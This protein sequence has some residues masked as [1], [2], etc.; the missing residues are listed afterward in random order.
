VIARLYNINQSHL[1]PAP[2]TQGA[3]PVTCALM[4]EARLSLHILPIACGGPDIVSN[5]QWQTIAGPFRAQSARGFHQKRRTRLAPRVR[6]KNP[7]CP[8]RR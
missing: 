3:A 4:P 2:R 7:R 1:I 6:R 8:V 5:L